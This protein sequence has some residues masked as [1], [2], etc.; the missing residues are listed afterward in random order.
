[1]DLNQDKTAVCPSPI[2]NNGI[3]EH[4][5]ELSSIHIGSAQLGQTSPVYVVAEAAC[6]HM[7][8]MDLA[9]K[10]IDKAASAGADAIKFQT[11]KAEKLVSKDAVAFWGNEK[12]RQL[13]YYKKLDRFGKEEYSVLFKYAEDKGIEPFSSPFDPES[14]SMLAELGM[15][16]F[17][18]ASC[19]INN[20]DFLKFIADFD[21]PIMLSTGASELTE[22]D[23]AVETIF[24][25]GN[26]KL[27]LL[28]CTLSYPTENKDANLLK[29]QT[30]KHRYPGVII[31]LS[32][33]TRP[34]PAMAIPAFGVAAGAR[35]IEKHYTLDRSM[36]GSGHFFAVDPG[37]LEE[38]VNNIRLAET[39]LGDGCFGVAESEK[40]AWQSARRSIV[41]ETLIPKGTLITRECL[42]FK[43]PGTGGMPASEINEVIGRKARADISPDQYLSIDMVE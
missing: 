4:L 18:I 35:I 31:G 15:K 10:M 1:M 23:R 17:K 36:T 9:L 16:V 33:H 14:A 27:M 28:A 3:K 12:M 21:L 39:V 11:Y 13:D 5:S 20:I 40:K 42:G 43:R 8:D 19:D 22:V 6:N 25:R 30:L 7:C 29:I 26:Y 37:H 2:I 24:S 41:A 32:D 34:D 38:M